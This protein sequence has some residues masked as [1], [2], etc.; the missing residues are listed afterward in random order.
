[1]GRVLKALDEHD[2]SARTLVIFTSD[3]GPETYAYERLRVHGH[4]SAGALRG[5]KRDIYEG[6]HRVPFVVRWPGRIE[7]G[8]VSGALMG[9]MDLFATI[10]A[11]IGVPVPEDAA[12]DSYNLLPVWTEAAPSPRRSIVHNTFPEVYAIRHEQ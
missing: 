5:V 8:R 9:Q 6:G 7:A 11:A 2:L 12:V 1:V 10:A 3:N 4:R